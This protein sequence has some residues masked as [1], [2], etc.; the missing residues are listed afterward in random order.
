MV[1]GRT[2]VEIYVEICACGCLGRLIILVRLAVVFNNYGRFCKDPV[3]GLPLYQDRTAHTLT[4]AVA[5]KHL[6]RPRETRWH[7]ALFASRPVTSGGI[8]SLV[9]LQE[10][11]KRGQLVIRIEPSP[12]K[13]CKIFAM[14]I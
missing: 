14:L 5:L 12:V 4:P 2:W 1:R 8:G 10:L 7:T 13:T 6:R 3:N 11:L 9:G